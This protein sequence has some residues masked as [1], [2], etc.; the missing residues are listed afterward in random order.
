M[1]NTTSPKII[2]IAASEQHREEIYNIRYNVYAEELHQHSA[3]PVGQLKDEL[4]LVNNY[5][6]AEYDKKVIGVISITSPASKKYSVD[7]YFNRS[8]PIF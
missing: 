3:N 5:I 4:D 1:A 8:T 7:K 2:L 6:V